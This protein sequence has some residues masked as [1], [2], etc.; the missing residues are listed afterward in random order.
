MNPWTKQERLAL[1]VLVMGL[2]AS[3]AISLCVPSRARAESIPSMANAY[4]ST[5][6]RSVRVVGG[7]DAPVALFAAQVHQ[8][9]RWDTSAVSPVGAR[10]LAQFMPQTARWLNTL[11]PENAGAGPI[12]SPSWSMRS[13]VDYDLWLFARV[14]AASEGDR[15]A[16]ALSG[17]N[18]G[19]GWVYKDEAAANAQGLDPARWWGQVESVNAG[20][21]VQ[22][23]RENRGYPRR[24]MRTLMPV[25][26][27]AGWGRGVN[28]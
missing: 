13:L 12:F 3:I 11:H 24:I 17:Y 9:S 21:A 23:F 25:Y 16:K 22:F 20:R 8:E 18:G 28:L 5:F 14:K 15:W 10:G 27:A 19:L 1:A 7:M 6:V 4:R 2:L 26:V